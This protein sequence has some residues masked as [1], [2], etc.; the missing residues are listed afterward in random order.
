[1]TPDK[2]KIEI[3][4]QRVIKDMSFIIKK[5][6]K[7]AV[8]TSIISKCLLENDPFRKSLRESSNLL[9]SYTST[10]H[11]KGSL[12]KEITFDHIEYQ[13]IFLESQL[14]TLW[15]S[16]DINEKNYSIL[17]ESISKVIE[18]LKN[19]HLPYDE[20]SSS[21]SGVG[22]LGRSLFKESWLSGDFSLKDKRQEFS[23]KDTLS[24]DTKDDQ[25]KAAKDISKRHSSD[26]KSERVNK[27]IAFIKDK[28]D[29]SLKDI[30]NLID[31]V[32]SKTLHRDLQ[33]LIDKGQVKQIGEKRWARYVYLR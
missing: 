31:N 28:K 2:N 25:V 23:I 24:N 5:T 3:E 6:H 33:Y 26:D 29:I 7:I 21:I 8:A 16:G 14:S 17:S 27:I 13:L 22:P 32:G 10:F 4:M 12:D 1:M 9:L 20:D 15:S 19:N 30:S 18:D 11:K